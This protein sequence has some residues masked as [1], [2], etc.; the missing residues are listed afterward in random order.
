MGY[1]V[2]NAYAIGFIMALGF[3][4]WQLITIRHYGVTGNSIMMTIGSNIVRLIISVAFAHLVSHLTMPAA[5]SS[6]TEG[7]LGTDL[8]NMQTGFDA[9]NDFTASSHPTHTPFRTAITLTSSL[10]TLGAMMC[11]RAR[12]FV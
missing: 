10:A 8:T 7:A 11:T 3:T 12:A 9:A 2:Q 1:V 4:C 6:A 5:L